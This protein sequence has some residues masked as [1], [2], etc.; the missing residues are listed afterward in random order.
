MYSFFY[1]QLKK[2]IPG[3]LSDLIHSI[4]LMYGGKHG[5][6][7]EEA[8]YQLTEVVGD[9]I[10]VVPALALAESRTGDHID[11]YT[12]FLVVGSFPSPDEL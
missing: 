6:T 5:M 12:F 2:F 1:L 9:L 10:Y 7:D 4:E 11:L 8:L 3:D